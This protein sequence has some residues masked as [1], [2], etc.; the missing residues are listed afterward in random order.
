MNGERVSDPKGVAFG[1]SIGSGFLFR[2]S[3]AG[4]ALRGLEDLHL[5]GLLGHPVHGTT[6]KIPVDLSPLSPSR[7]ASRS[8]TQGCCPFCLLLHWWLRSP[9]VTHATNE[10]I[11]QSGGTP[12]TEYGGGRPPSDSYGVAFGFSMVRSR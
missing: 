2:G 1:S 10:Q 7:E 4:C 12:R 3:S 5:T 9:S 11:V 8:A 6:M